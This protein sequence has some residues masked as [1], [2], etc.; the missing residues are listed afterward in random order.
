VGH[1]NCGSFISVGKQR[2]LTAA[3]DCITYHAGVVDGAKPH[4]MVVL[5]TPVV[6]VSHSPVLKIP[7]RD[8][9]VWGS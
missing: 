5:D 9:D 1:C 6:Q 8:L 7:S 4:A 3:W 2:L